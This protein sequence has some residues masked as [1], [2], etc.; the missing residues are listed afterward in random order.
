MWHPMSDR[1]SR[2][3]EPGRRGRPRTKVR[4]KRR[5]QAEIWGEMIR[6][7]RE[8]H[9]LTQVQFAAEIQRRGESLPCTASTVS[10]W[11]TGDREPAMQYRPVIAEIF[12]MPST[13]L[14]IKINRGAAA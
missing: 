8:G 4:E 14:F 3:P 11:E 10:K 5:P 12:E 9:N 13:A 1:L 2:S 7:L 6:S